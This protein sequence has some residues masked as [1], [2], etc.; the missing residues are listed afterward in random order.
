M[1]GS[2]CLG[3]IR[4]LPSNFD[5][6]N[7]QWKSFSMWVSGFFRFSSCNVPYLHIRAMHQGGGEGFF[8]GHDGVLR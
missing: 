6:S 3:V 1:A 7:A 4:S 8:H 5:V 2:L